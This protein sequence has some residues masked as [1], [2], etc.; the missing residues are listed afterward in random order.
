SI[1]STHLI[2]VI[3]EAV[4][5]AL[6][7]GAPSQIDI[8]IYGNRENISFEVRD[9][10]KGFGLSDCDNGNG[11]RNMR[12]RL[13][14]LSGTLEVDSNLTGGTRISGS[15]PVERNVPEAPQ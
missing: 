15:F 9:N 4:N 13:S 12:Y 5:N 6:K 1:Q 14:M 2:R 3:Q 7:H 11:I 8:L 10:G